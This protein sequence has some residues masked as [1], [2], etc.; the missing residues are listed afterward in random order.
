MADLYLHRR[1][2][3]SIFELL[4][5]K[6][7]DITYSI[8]WALARSPAFLRRLVHHVLPDA[9][10]QEPAVH[11]QEYQGGGSGFTDIEIWGTD[12]RVIIEAKRGWCLPERDQLE[13]YAKRPTASH[14]SHTALVAMSECSPEYA[15]LHL[16][17]AVCGHPVHHVGWKE[18]ARL[19]VVPKASH[20]EKRLLA[21]L[22]TYFARIV[23]MQNQTSNMVYVVA[24]GGGWPKEP[25]NYIGFRYGGQLRSVHHVDDWKI[26]KDIH[27]ELPEI[28][29]QDW[30]AHFLYT[31]GPPIVLS[32]TVKSGKVYPNGR[33]W[34]MLDLLL[35][36]DTVSDARDLTQQ[37]LSEEP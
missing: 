14:V 34:A 35:T 15:K 7:N 16:P 32:K 6:E 5:T 13:K 1:K 31:L 17:K 4:G 12:F 37:R 21:E 19:T 25:P 20:A 28:P 36:R 29:D 3:D 26:V 9:V 24:L 11:L 22:R 8:G 2:L 33:V 30:P 18:V 23:R 10:L 27:A